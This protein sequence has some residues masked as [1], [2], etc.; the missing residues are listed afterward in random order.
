MVT[1]FNNLDEDCQRLIIQG[2]LWGTKVKLTRA[3]RREGGECTVKSRR[4]DSIKPL[5]LAWKSINVL[6]EDELNRF[7]IF[8]LRINGCIFG[9]YLMK[10][11][12]KLSFNNVR[13][14]RL[15]LNYQQKDWMKRQVLDQER[16]P[17]ASKVQN[18]TVEVAKRLCC[19]ATLKQ[20]ELIV[21]VDSVTLNDHHRSLRRFLIF[22]FTNI[23]NSP[24]SLETVHVRY[25]IMEKN[26]LVSLSKGTRRKAAKGWR[27][28][29]S[30]Y[31]IAC[32]LQEMATE[33]KTLGL[34]DLLCTFC[35]RW[36]PQRIGDLTGQYPEDDQERT[37]CTAAFFIAMDC[38]GSV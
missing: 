20:L 10:W 32:A 25:I 1:S 37:D 5:R 28:D 21:M 29:M 18:S 16:W 13:E 17:C 19:F 31:K 35:R 38:D 3:E 15:V 30:Q 2:L 14:L 26:D 34:H 24:K 9:T 23:M 12:E 22:E 11:I 8:E 36:Q 6:I 4:P 7:R 33:L 27:Q